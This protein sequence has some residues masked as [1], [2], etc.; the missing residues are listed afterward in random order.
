[1][2]NNGMD[3]NGDLV[4]ESRYIDANEKVFKIYIHIYKYFINNCIKSL[5]R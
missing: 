4:V 5:R 3:K 1:M 2:L